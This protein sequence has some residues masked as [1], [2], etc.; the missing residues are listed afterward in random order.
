MYSGE[1]DFLIRE[2]VISKFTIEEI[3][4]GKEKRKREGKE[5]RRKK[6]RGIRDGRRKKGR[7]KGEKY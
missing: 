5:M 1:I 7:I 4:Q 6:G 2:I 3:E